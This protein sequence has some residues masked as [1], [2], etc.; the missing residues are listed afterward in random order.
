VID[1]TL[2]H[3]CLVAATPDDAVRALGAPWLGVIE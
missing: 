1:G 3:A 2:H